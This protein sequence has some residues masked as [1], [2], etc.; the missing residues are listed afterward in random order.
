MSVCVNN[1]EKLPSGHFVF[2]NIKRWLYTLN[3][4]CS[5]NRKE[6]KATPLRF[7]FGSST[8]ER[9][10]RA[11]RDWSATTAEPT[12]GQRDT[13]AKKEKEKKTEKKRERETDFKMKSSPKHAHVSSDVRFFSKCQR[14]FVRRLE[15]KKKKE[16]KKKTWAIQS[17]GDPCRTRIGKNKK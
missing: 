17:K 2:S 9:L 11:E 15:E 16:K 6:T 5:T 1:T 13:R 4:T 10:E 14:R 3:V 12:N 8:W 7:L